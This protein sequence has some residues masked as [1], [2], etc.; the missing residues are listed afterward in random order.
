M[1]SP[2][3]VEFSSKVADALDEGM[4][5]WRLPVMPKNVLTNRPYGGINP[6]LLNIAASRLKLSSPYWGTDG[7]WRTL[8]FK[9]CQPDIEDWSTR[10]LLLKEN[11]SPTARRI[12]SHRPVREFVYNLDQTDRAYQSILPSLPEADPANAFDEVVKKAG[13]RIEYG[14]DTT[15]KYIGSEDRIRMPHKCM[16]EIGPGGI[17]GYYDALGHELLHWSEVR[18]GWDGDPDVCELRADIGTGYLGALLGAKPLPPHLAR[19]HRKHAGRWASLMRADPEM[20]FKVCE[21]VTTTVTY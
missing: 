4:I 12:A 11:K 17:S 16:F 8:G 18:M 10:I 5:P 2:L 1:S 15:C 3:T 13:V 21:N 9:V 6:I 20:L 7:Q 19:H 14:Y